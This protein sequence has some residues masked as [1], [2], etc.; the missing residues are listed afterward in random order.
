MSKNHYARATLTVEAALIMPFFLYF[1]IAFLYF[2]QLFSL[3]EHIQAAITKLG[4]DFSKSAYIYEELSLE[5][6]VDFD[7][8]IFGMDDG[9]GV[10]ELASSIMDQVILKLYAMKYLKKDILDHSGIHQ[11]MEGVSFEG[12]NILDEQGC[13]DIIVSYKVKIPITVFALKNMKMVQRI[14]LRAW[15]G[16]EVPSNYTKEDDKEEIIV[17]VTE[18]GSVYHKNRECSHIRL[19]IRSVIGVPNGLR[20][21][22][23]GKY[24]PCESCCKGVEDPFMTYYITSDGTRYHT[25]NT[26][27]RIKRNVKEV[28]ISEVGSRKPCKRCG[29]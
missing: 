15:T 7:Q 26:C 22:N 11:G 21:D 14:K 20:N 10:Q 12:S 24:Y 5:E 23:G 28:R 27:S 18:T 17:Y 25:S 6:I 4:L 8:S 13:I 9:I 16:H 29:N 1:M 19:S 2:I 3:Q